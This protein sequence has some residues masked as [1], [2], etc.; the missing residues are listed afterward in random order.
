MSAQITREQYPPTPCK[1]CGEVLDQH[2]D[3]CPHCGVDRPLDTVARTRP[4]AALRALGPTAAAAPVPV[5]AKLSLA[6]EPA[7]DRPRVK[8]DYLRHSPLDDNSSF[9]RTGRF[10]SAKGL[11]LAGFLVVIASAAY[12]V[13]GESHRQESPIDDQREHSSGGAVSPYMPEQRTS[14]MLATADT[15]PPSA[16]QKAHGTPQSSDMRNRLRA[17][18]ASLAKGRLSDAKA[19]VN[20]ALLLDP[21]NE[22]ARDIQRDI[23]AREQR[24]DSALQSAD[25]CAKQQ[26]WACVQQQA[27]EALAI[28][29]GSLR[30]QSLMESAI[31]STAWPAL[32]PPSGSSGSQNSVVQ[33]SATVP[34][35]RD[36]NTVRL[37]SSQDWYAAAPTASKER[38]A[39]APL[40]PLP[41]TNPANTVDPG[42]ANA[43]VAT[44]AANPSGAADAAGP[45]G[46]D[47]G[48]DAEEHAIV[49][50]GW[51]H[52]MSS[53]DGTH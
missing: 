33:A 40:P 43:S 50:S 53:S 46:N 19:A 21:D 2:V 37:P 29:A 1:R 25:A 5:A 48:L 10:V 45:A 20:A 7:S 35:P 32:R 18:R 8:P 13:L 31:R 24:R 51:T 47:N 23:A 38:T 41:T 14:A 36:T 9:G 42:G 12:L 3:F 49:Q 6:G 44:A 17:A 15:G 52:A 11:V 34:L 28:D 30:A 22:D 16:T 27:S 4:K 39:S 26:A